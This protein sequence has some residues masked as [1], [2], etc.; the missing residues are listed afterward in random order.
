MSKVDVQFSPSPCLV[1]DTILDLRQALED[2]CTWLE[3]SYPLAFV[4]EVIKGDVT[5]KFPR[6]Y[7]N[8]G[9][10]KYIDVMPDKKLKAFSFF[11]LN[12]DYSID[13]VIDEV[14][15]SVSIIFWANLKC[16]DKRDYD[17]KT[18]LI[19]DALRSLTKSSVSCDITTIEV[20]ENFEDIF[21]K[22]S[23]EQKNMQ[24]FMY[25][26]T[27]WKFT[28]SVTQDLNM[29]CCLP[30]TTEDCVD[31][32][33][34][35]NILNLTFNAPN[36]PSFFYVESTGSDSSIN[37]GDDTGNQVSVDVVE[38][39]YEYS[40]ANNYDVSIIYPTIS[41]ITTLGLSQA[42]PGSIV[43]VLDLNE[44][45]GLKLLV[46]VSHELITNVILP[47]NSFDRIVFQEG[48][49][50]I[51]INLTDIN[52]GV[53][54]ARYD[55]IDNNFTSTFINKIL[56]D[57]DSISTTGFT[58]RILNLQNNSA[59]TGLGLIAKSNLIS[60]GFTVTTD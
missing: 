49:G 8:D 39:E 18:E 5:H 48:N 53:N 27:S 32:I 55:F 44:F 56:I 54:N 10:N 41:L 3:E 47:S 42:E 6:I 23:Y 13:R 28:F 21:S 1:E 12:G 52:T 30:F 34:P 2:N 14:T 20:T 59:P 4:G 17:Y 50:D 60:K 33:Y 40:L 22:Y 16:I 24:F 9:S 43:G 11:E 26:F 46:L 29:S 31:Y 38:L 37:F 19:Q 25:P 36:S 51:S 57:L 35:T 15:S 45:K 7:R 58:G